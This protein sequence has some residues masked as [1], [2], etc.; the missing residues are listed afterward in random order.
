M[1]WIV[2][3]GGLLAA[4]CPLPDEKATTSGPCPTK[5]G[6]VD[7]VDTGADAL[8]PD[9]TFAPDG[10]PDAEVVVACADTDCHDLWVDASGSTGDQ[11]DWSSETD[12]KFTPSP[13]PSIIAIEMPEVGRTAT[14]LLGV[15]SSAD[16]ERCDGLSVAVRG[17]TYEGE[18]ARR[19]AVIITPLWVTSTTT[20]VSGC[21]FVAGIGGCVT[22]PTV[23]SYSAVPTIP[24]VPAFET[25]LDDPTTE[26]GF[27]TWATWDYSRD[28]TS[29]L[30]GKLGSPPTPFVTVAGEAAA[31][32]TLGGTSYTDYVLLGWSV[33]KL[34]RL[35]VTQNKLDDQGNVQE[36][37]SVDTTCS[38]AGKGTISFK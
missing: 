10:V 38:S 5:G 3:L 27:A 36:V 21:N 15:R 2:G 30:N 29:K 14:Y 11:F 26:R 35:T 9:T 34:G 28:A 32:T 37:Q 16:P 4:G 17:I 22:D 20:R 24:T 33:N 18:A 12:S 25:A 23:A 8:E 7:G 31:T 19:E 13:D 6:T 1:R